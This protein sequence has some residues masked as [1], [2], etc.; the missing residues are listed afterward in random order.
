M[1]RHSFATATLFN[2]GLAWYDLGMKTCEMLASSGVV[3]NHRVGRM[4]RAGVSPNARDRKEF[5]LMGTEKSKA[6]HDSMLAVLTRLTS[7]NLA[8]MSGVW[9]PAN[10][11][12]E[13]AHIAHAALAPIHRKATANARRLTATKRTPKRSSKGA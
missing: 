13:S 10:A 1:T 5:M 2:P 6:A 11:F 12:N 7:A 9:R 3:I 8:M 4:A